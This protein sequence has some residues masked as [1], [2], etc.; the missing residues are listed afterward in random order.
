VVLPVPPRPVCVGFGGVER[1]LGWDD[2]VGIVD[3]GGL[4]VVRGLR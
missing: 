3:G 2:E 1:V 4:R